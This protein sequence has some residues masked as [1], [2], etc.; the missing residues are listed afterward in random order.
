[1]MYARTLLAIYS[2]LYAYV[3]KLNTAGLHYRFDRGILR[4]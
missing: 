3:T 4:R 1:M 2:E